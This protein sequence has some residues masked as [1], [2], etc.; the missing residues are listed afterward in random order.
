M[1]TIVED[2][3]NK[4]YVLIGVGYGAT[5]A[6]RPSAASGLFTTHRTSESELAAVANPDGEIS[7][8]PAHELTV[9]SVDGYSCRDWLNSASPDR[10]SDLNR[11]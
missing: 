9:I 4:R 6:M 5:Q 7:W 1:A 2:Y 11:S 8:V 3:R 10:T